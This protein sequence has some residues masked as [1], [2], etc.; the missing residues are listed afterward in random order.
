MKHFLTLTLALLTAK[1][2]SQPAHHTALT[3]NHANAL[4]VLLAPQTQDAPAMKATAVTAQRVIAQSTRD[5]TLAALSDSLDLTYTGSN[6]SRYDYNMMLYPYN[7]VYS[8]SPMFDFLGIFTK[9]QVLFDECKHWTINPFTL[10]YGYYETT[11][12]TYDGS[13]NQA[14]FKHTYTDSVTN[15]NM[16]FVN[17]FN[18]A[19]K[20]TRGSWFNW[21]AGVMD[22][23][24]KQFF[25]YNTANKLTQDSTYELHLGTWRLV[26]KTN[27]TYDATNNL[28]TINNYANV[29]DTSLTLPLIE[30]LRYNNTYDASNRLITVLTS[31]HDGTSLI[32][33]VKDTFAYTGAGAF[34]TSWRQ[35]QRDIINNYW[36]PWIKMEKHL[37]AGNL[38]DT[39]NTFGFD[40]LANMWMPAAR[41]IISYNT[42]NNPVTMQNYQYA[43]TTFPTTPTFT[44]TY[45][46]ENYQD[47]TSTPAISTQATVT[48]FPNPAS[49]TITIS[50]MEN[51]DGNLLTISIT[52]IAGRMIAKETA[53]WH[54]SRQL[55]V[56]YLLP[57][58]YHITIQTQPGRILHQSSIVK[59]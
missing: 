43:W 13:K 7:Y 50:G 46:Y 40:S 56:E 12:G 47:A 11:Y 49:N 42:M 31:M 35:H 57:A 27:Y 4:S 26:S 39:V 54:R 33:Y 5:N 23:A 6:Y 2:F 30:Q 17:A 25:S 29:A 55:S 34:H 18:T 19:N 48:I 3:G 16:S 15:K 53:P 14:T 1:A 8:T 36:A 37:N 44:T 51:Q 9:P 52:D 58:S 38:P 28:I 21:N 22:S 41:D 10:V 59:Y 32:Q 24:F 45:Y 20:I